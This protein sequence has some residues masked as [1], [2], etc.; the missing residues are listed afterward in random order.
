MRD[1]IK[2]AT[3]GNSSRITVKHP[4]LRYL[5]WKPN[6][7]LMVTLKP[8]GRMEVC[9]L[10]TYIQDRHEQLKREEADAARDAARA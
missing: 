5:K 1:S 9:T 10:E 3:H 8:G 2:L 6:E 7:E 4:M